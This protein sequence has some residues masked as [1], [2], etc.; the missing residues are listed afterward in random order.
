MFCEY[1]DSSDVTLASKNAMSSQLICNF[2][3]FDHC[4]LGKLCRHMPIN[5]IW[6][7]L[8][9]KGNHVHKGTLG[10]ANIS[11]ALT[12]ACL[13]YTAL[14]SNLSPSPQHFKW[15]LTPS[16]SHEKLSNNILP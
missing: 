11:K 8:I 13:E 14:F 1:C 7:S 3:N 15:R 12:S 10:P 5:I 16:R 9:V 2:H 4:K 6:T